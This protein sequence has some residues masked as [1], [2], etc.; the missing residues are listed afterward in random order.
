MEDA[1]KTADALMALMRLIVDKPEQM[2]SV[3]VP[4]GSG[5]MIRVSASPS[6]IGM[7]IGKQGRIARALRTILSSA[8]MKT[9]QRISL[10][11]G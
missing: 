7:L 11:I 5:W 4:D 6:D 3:V 10:D 2:S 8:S 1:Q 9:K